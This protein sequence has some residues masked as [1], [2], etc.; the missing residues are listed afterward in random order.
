MRKDTVTRADIKTYF[1]LCVAL[2]FAIIPASMQAQ[3]TQ[4][5]KDKA[6]QNLKSSARVNPSTLAMEFSL[7]LGNYPGRAGNSMPVTFN[8]SSKVW[9]MQMV[10]TRY[11]EVTVS[12]QP[13]YN[14][15]AYHNTEVNALFAEKSWAGWT[16]SLRPFQLIGSVE[17]FNAYGGIYQTGIAGSNTSLSSEC[18][19]VSQGFFPSTVC[20]SGFEFSTYTMCCPSMGDCAPYINNSCLGVDPNAPVGGGNSQGP[21]QLG[22]KMVYR[23][24]IEMPDG[25]TKEFRK[26]DLLRDCTADE[27][28]CAESQDGT[29]LSVD[30]SG[31][32]FERNEIQ[33][34][35]SIRDVL[36]MPDGSKYIFPVI[37]PTPAAG[38]LVDRNGNFSLYDHGN[39]EWT[40]TMGR[41]IVDPIPTAPFNQIPEPGTQTVTVK[42]IANADVDYDVEWKKLE[43]VLENPS[44]DLKYRGVDACDGLHENQIRGDSLFANQPLP[45]EPGGDPADDQIENQTWRLRTHRTCAAM[46]GATPAIFNPTVMDSITLP[47]GKKY[48]FKYNEYG[49]ITKI[50]YPT[51][52]YERFEYGFVQP[53]GMTGLEIYTQGNRGVLKRYVSV[54]GT[55]ESQ[56]W[57][58][59]EISDSNGYAL[60][61]EAPDGSKTERVL[62]SSTGSN[63]GFEDPR[64]GMPKEERAYDANGVLRSRTINDWT[65]LGPQGTGAYG[66]AKRDPRV[67]RSV[68][69]T[70]EPN[71][72]SALAVLSET[73]HDDTGSADPEYFSHLNVKQKRGYHYAVVTKTD[74]DTEQL[75]WTTI[76]GWFSGKLAAV[77]ETD[78]SYSSNYK[79]RGIIGLPVES[80]VLNPTNTSDVLSKSRP[81][82]DETSIYPIIS[83]G[84]SSTWTD[85]GSNLRGNVTTTRQWVKEADTWLESHAQFDNFGNLRKVWDASGDATKYIETEYS[86]T[87]NYAYPT[88]VITPS[89]ATSSIATGHATTDTSS[90]ETTYDT[91]TGLVLTVKDDFGQITATEYDD[92]LMRPTRVYGANFT[93]PIAVTE[94]DDTNR[95]VTVKKQIDS[96]NWDQA[97]TFADS[98]G[99]PIKTVAKDSQGDVIVETKYDLLGRANLVTNPYRDG[100]TVYWNRTRFDEVGRAVESY[101]P[102]SWANASVADPESNSNLVSLGTTS[103]GISTVTNYVGTFTVTN[104]ASGRKSR[105]ITNAL[106]QLLRIDEP[107]AIG[108]ANDADL[109]SLASP[110]Q[111]TSYA[112]D[113]YGNM[114]KVTQGAQSRYFKYDSLGRL[115]RVNQPELETNPN[116]G[117]GDAF[118]VSGQWTAAFTYDELG[119]VVT[120]TDAKNVSIGNS[121]DRAGRVVTRAYYGEATLGLTPSVYFFYDGKGLDAEQT[122]E[123]FAKGKLTK[124]DNTI[125]LTR[126][127]KFDNFGRLK[128]M[129]Q[130]T[131]ATPTETIFSATPRVSKYTYNLSGALIEEEYPSGRV[132]KNEFESD[133]DLMRVSGRA[134]SSAPE[135]TYVNGFNYTAAGGIKQMKL[136]NG[137]W[138]TAQFNERG[139]VT[140]L[141]LG[142]SATNASLWK[143]DYHY[144]ELEGNGSISTSKNTGNIAR[145]TLTIPGTSFTQSYK[146]DAVYR[147]TEAKE[148]TGTSTTSNWTQTF[149]YDVYGNRTSFA[150]NIGG[151]TNNTTPAVDSSTNRFTSSSFTYDKNGN[152]TADVDPATSQAR[153]FVFNGDNKQIEIKDANGNWIGRYFYDGEGKRVKKVAGSETTVFVYSSAK[154]VAEYSTQTSSTPTIAYTTTDHL[155][156]PRIITDKYGAVRSRRDFMPFGEDVFVGVGGRTGDSGQ[157]YASS[158]DDVRQ[159]FTGYQKDTETSLDFAEAR[160]YENRHGRFTAVDPL[161]ASGKSAN[162]QTFNR[163]VYVGNNPIVITD[164]SGLDWYFNESENRYDWYDEKSKRFSYS[165]ENYEIKWENWKLLKG[166]SEFVYIDNA[167][168]NGTYVALD[169]Y[170]KDFKP[171]LSSS[172]ANAKAAGWYASSPEVRSFLDAFDHGADE[173]IKGRTKGFLNICI[174]F[175]NS[176]T[177][178]GGISGE[179]AGVENPL[180]MERVSYDSPK[181]AGYG[182]ATEIGFNLGTILAGGTFSHRGSTSQSIIPKTILEPKPVHGNSLESLRPTWG[183]RLYLRSDDT[184]LKNGI[185]SQTKAQSRYTKAYMSD[186]YMEVQLFCNRRQA[187]IWEIEQNTVNPGP[188]NFRR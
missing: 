2:I 26:D 185:T 44:W 114:V 32:R 61:T 109:G 127:T 22:V 103:F 113:L 152:I 97:T 181:Q 162:P 11:E 63:Y 129:E 99:R 54:D 139:Q 157:K 75:S 121:Y 101:A 122:P 53:M 176:S 55:T 43:D 172:D 178:P 29:Y 7:P 161:L 170:S 1:V 107:T 8:Y 72:S 142:T 180:A 57:T 12:G 20:E 81:V 71:S 164:P 10:N 28:N 25:S 60:R 188:L 141:G 186:K 15:I 87:Y 67:K 92:P 74:V 118:N 168:K 80:R 130:R 78:Y 50:K 45:G 148:V 86:S 159:K 111:A 88:K 106:G 49:E 70:F 41:E 35:T 100:D 150:Q 131:P 138:E 90:V 116:I 112:Y 4:S 79:S 136:G 68:S 158:V 179:G 184:F 134:N 34:D 187:R 24:R 21:T 151:V 27:E 123:N 30:G 126:Y 33:A 93:A 171:G 108:G 48:E 132:V 174:A 146:Y 124:V 95:T 177:Q 47:N 51:G 17:M 145:Q 89:P 9:N 137:K 156:S 94:Y 16:S 165:N 23:F 96:T 40:D 135:Q 149:G 144:G 56:E 119:N 85:P 133:G 128:E 169:R 73:D 154:L 140:Q 66:E 117:L 91:P 19:L 52:G 110:A 173:S 46:W 31:M 167:A 153:A 38:K 69:L 166:A 120:A 18:F 58:Y 102:A 83:A 82:Y 105:S 77:S 14:K 59:S 84:T 37:S 36:Y 175:W 183:Y 155:G 3:N 62:H 39:N 98:L 143:T 147:L 6:D 65:V 160:M 42:G 64:N 163:Y 5:S 76:T 104:D 182:I 125:S 13:T 115:I